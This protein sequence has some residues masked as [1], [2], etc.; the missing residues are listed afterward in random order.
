LRVTKKV[1][2]DLMILTSL[3]YQIIRPLRVDQ[4]CVLSEYSKKST[5]SSKLDY[6][7]AY[8]YMV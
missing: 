6:A 8:S 7:L 2:K 5:S 4:G 1:Y 3:N